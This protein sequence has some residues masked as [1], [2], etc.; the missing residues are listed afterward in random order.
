MKATVISFILLTVIVVFLI[1]NGV[2][3]VNFAKNLEE[4][5]DKL[6]NEPADAINE[7][8]IL[9]DY[10]DKWEPFV[11]MSVIHLESEAVTDAMTLMLEYAKSGD[12][13]EYNATK[14]K[15]KNA[16]KHIRFYG[17]VSLETIL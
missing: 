6:S 1:I 5:I 3:L 11:S 15:L 2:L 9:C 7:V 13:A 4:H 12:K 8:R 17:A 14:E 16:I 10:W